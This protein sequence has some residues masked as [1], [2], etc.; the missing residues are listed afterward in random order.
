M[1]FFT[2]LLPSNIWF[3]SGSKLSWLD[4]DGC[5]NNVLFEQSVVFY[6]PVLEDY[7]E[8]EART[9]TVGK[10]RFST[11]TS[12]AQVSSPDTNLS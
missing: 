8:L 5:K 12:V 7:W 11:F 10:V 3:R 1:L 2:C 6:W 4:E 9:G